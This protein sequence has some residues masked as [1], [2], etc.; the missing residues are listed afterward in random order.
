MTSPNSAFAVPRSALTLVESLLVA[1]ILALLLWL[2]TG[3]YQREL[4]VARTRQSRQM[5]KTL[6]AALDAYHEATG[7][8]PLGTLHGAADQAI[9]AL[10]GH[11]DSGRHL[12]SLDLALLHMRDGRPRCI[13]P[14]GKRL[15]FISQQIAQPDLRRRF[16]ANAH[17]PIFESSGP[18]QTFG[19]PNQPPTADDI[20][21]DDPTP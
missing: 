10:L 18:D 1:L 21:T 5:L 11:P 2:T 7:T 19:L 8:Y 17:K 9:A 13:D 12:Q 3:L 20:R 16:Q 15:R 4:N 6:D 14:W